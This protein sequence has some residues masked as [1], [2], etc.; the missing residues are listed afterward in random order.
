MKKVLITGVKGFLGRNIA[1]HFSRSG[2]ETYGI[3]HG[4]ISPEECETIGLKFWLEAEITVDTLK[5]LNQKFDLIFHCAGSGSVGF[6]IENPYEDFKK[7]VDG[8]LEVLEYL[9]LYN[10]DAQLIY[11]SSPAVQGEHPDAPIKEEYVGK[12]ASPYGYHK[13]IAE[14]LCRSYSEKYALSVKIIRLFS[15]YGNGLQK[16]LLWD[17]YQKLTLPREQVEFWGTG[18]ET[19]DFIHISDVLSLIDIIIAQKE[20]FMIINGASGIKHT[21]AEVITLIRNNLLPA[22][23]ISFNNQVNIGNPIYYWADMTHLNRLNWKPK[24][25]FEEGVQNYIDWAKNL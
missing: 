25:S 21:V 11:P 1:S 15:V 14:D 18:T 24:I 3:G 22:C 19:R 8:T 23:S 17:A 20:H 16:Q 9:R 2:Y 10:P 5:A 4:N 12:P 6:S 7:T 13:K